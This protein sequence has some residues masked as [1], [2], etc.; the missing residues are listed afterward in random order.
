MKQNDLDVRKILDKLPEGGR[1]G[2]EFYLII[3]LI[4]ILFMVIIWPV[5]KGKEKIAEQNERVQNEDLTAWQSKD[6]YKMEGSEGEKE[7]SETLEQK[8]EDFLQQ[9]QGVGKAK[10]L[11][12]VKSQ[13]D[14][15]WG[16]EKEPQVEGVVVAMQGGGDIRI[17]K[18]VSE[19]L[20]ALFGIEAHKIKVVKLRTAQTGGIS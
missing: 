3:L 20:Q 7:T 2:K 15:L 9:M 16:S 1:G 6:I 13:K 19:V 11:L 8:L 10:V 12:Y 5:P 18:E 4:G 17:K 14:D